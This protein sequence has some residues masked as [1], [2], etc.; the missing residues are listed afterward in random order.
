M[1]N[2]EGLGLLTTWIT[3]GGYG[4]WGLGGVGGGA[5]SVKRKAQAQILNMLQTLQL[6]LNLIKVGSSQ[7]V[8]SQNVNSQ[9]VNSQNVNSQN[10]NS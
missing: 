7:N 9:N 2:R 4:G 8:N 6:D 1:K 3:S 10:V 5:M